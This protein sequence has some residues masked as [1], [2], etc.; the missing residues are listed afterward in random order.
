VGDG[1]RA[2]LR[3]VGGRGAAGDRSETPPDLERRLRLAAAEIDHAGLYDYLIVNEDLEAAYRD[4]KAVVLAARCRTGRQ[5]ERLQAITG[6][7]RTS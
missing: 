2:P 4:L 6:R 7:F 1:G 5:R 3:H